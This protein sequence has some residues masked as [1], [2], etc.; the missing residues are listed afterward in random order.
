MHEQVGGGGRL[1][2]RIGRRVAAGSGLFEQ[3]S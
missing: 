3:S 1:G 2:H